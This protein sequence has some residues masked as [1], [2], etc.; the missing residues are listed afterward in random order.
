MLGKITNPVD[1]SD[2]V[3]RLKEVQFAINNTV[4]RSTGASPNMLLFGVEQKGPI[5]DYLTE[6]LSG[7]KDTPRVDLEEIRKEADVNIKKS[8]DYASKWFNENSK[9]AKN[10]LAGD[11]VYILNV[12]TTPGNKK[13]IPKFKGPYTVVKVLPNDRYVIGDVEGMQVSQIPYDGV[14]EARNIRLWKRIENNTIN[15]D[16]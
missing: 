2:W 10:Y 5:V 15:M 12:Y 13:F 16:Q 1:N 9:G 14:I 8:Q 7:V 3:K 11:L 4:S 6:F